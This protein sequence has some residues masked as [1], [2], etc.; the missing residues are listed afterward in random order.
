MV[1]QAAPAT[2]RAPGPGAAEDRARPGS[3]APVA[4]SRGAGGVAPPAAGNPGCPAPP[5]PSAWQPR[6]GIGQQRRPNPAAWPT[7]P[8]AGAM[9]EEPRARPGAARSQHH[10]PQRRSSGRA[11]PGEQLPDVRRNEGTSSRAAAWWTSMAAPSRAPPWAAP[12]RSRPSPSRP[13]GETSEGHA[14]SYRKA[15]RARRPRNAALAE[16]EFD[17]PNRRH[18][19]LDLTDLRLF[20]LVNEAGSIAARRRRPGGAG[21]SSASARLRAGGTARHCPA[22]AQAAGR[23]RR[24]AHL[25]QELATAGPCAGH[26]QGSSTPCRARCPPRLRPCAA[27]GRHRHPQRD[28][29][30][31]PRRVPDAPAAWM[32]LDD[33]PSTAGDGSEA[34]AEELAEL[35]GKAD[36][37]DLSGL[38]SHP[39]RDDRLV[40]IHRP[41]MRWRR[42][43][44]DF[45]QYLGAS[46][47]AWRGQRPAPA[48]PGPCPPR[49]APHAPAPGSTPVVA[50]GARWRWC[51]VHRRRWPACPCC[52]PDG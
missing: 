20:L 27:A 37:T 25:Q 23:A 31:P 44:L 41:A 6:R 36:H 1:K 19:H 47:S 5:Q 15:H 7:P 10:P 3:A 11:R 16:A 48:Y 50:L 21:A 30:G 40:L 46:S 13:E 12:G 28:P 49:R 24:A 26:A 34:V 8:P 22:G 45:A 14:R 35:G 32:E 52:T 29:A 51:R 9:V 18:M 43:N 2:R 39:F 33:R 42:A 38:E 17:R 4:P